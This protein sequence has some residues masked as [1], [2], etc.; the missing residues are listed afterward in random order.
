MIMKK[1]GI[2]KIENIITNDCYVGSAISIKDRFRRHKKDLRKGK[3]HSVILLRSWIK[4]GEKAFVFSV[5]EECTNLQL[6]E[7][8]NYY[9]SLLKPAYNICPIAYSQVGRK[10]SAEHKE[11]LRQ[12]ALKNKVKPPKETY[13]FKQR[14][15]DMLDPA[16]NVIM[17]FKSLSEACRYVGKDYRSASTVAACCNGKRKTIY[18]HRW[19]WTIKKKLDKLN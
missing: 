16:G 5:L 9:I 1:S 8:E 4:Y 12:Y 6:A 17:S 7:R 13:E 10:L 3:H 11:K 14:S 18:G 2:Y 15:V 19:Q